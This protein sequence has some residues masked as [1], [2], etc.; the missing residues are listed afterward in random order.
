MTTFKPF[1]VRELEF[2]VWET[3]QAKQDRYMKQY[4]ELGLLGGG[5]HMM[6]GG[7]GMPGMSGMPGMHGMP[8]MSGMP[9]MTGMH[10]I[11]GM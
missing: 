2:E 5:D 7:M 9:S 1:T 4:E 3:S 6:G 11:S 8:G 10:G